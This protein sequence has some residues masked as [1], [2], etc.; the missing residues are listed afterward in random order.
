MALKKIEVQPLFSTP[1]FRAD[2]SD[3]ISPE[4]IAFIQKLPMNRNQVNQISENLYIF[5][6]P[7]LK[8][9][10]DAVKEALDTYAREV[11]GISQKLSVTQSWALT[12][13]PGVGMHAHAHSNSIVS[14]SLYYAPLPS[15]PARMIFDR[16]DGYRQI[17]LVPAQGKRNIFNTPMN[18]IE[19]RTGEIVLF[20]SNLNH[21]VEQNTSSQPRH[22]IA[23]NSFVRGKIGDFR[24]VSEL[25][26]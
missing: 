25:N 6:L 24:D 26:V 21:M 15:P 2:I 11:M 19:P 14:G 12:N 18:V 20:P 16:Y 1:V 5:N 8:S 17:E 22:A 9:I 13:P 23:F 7:E 4:Q 10:S 3:H